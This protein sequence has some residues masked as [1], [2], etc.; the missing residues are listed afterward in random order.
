VVAASDASGTLGQAEFDFVVGRATTEFDRVDID[1]LTLQE[2]SG[3]TR[4]KYYTFATAKDIPDQLEKSRRRIIYHEELTLWN[5]PG[6]FLI[7]LICVAAEW[8][9]RKRFALS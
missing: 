9:L 8:F 3:Q 7:F 2:I 1:E 4:G 6:F 5:A